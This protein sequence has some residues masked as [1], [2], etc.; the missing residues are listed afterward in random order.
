LVVSNCAMERH[1]AESND[2]LRRLSHELRTP[3]TSIKGYT[4]L[5]LDGAA[6]D[7]SLDQRDLLLAVG[8]NVDR[9]TVTINDF[10]V[11]RAPQATAD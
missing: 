1:P 8:R 5:L 11:E 9:L 10:L 4:E 3:L 7:L 6:G 2:A